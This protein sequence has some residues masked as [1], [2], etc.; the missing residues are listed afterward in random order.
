MH[1]HKNLYTLVKSI[2]SSFTSK[3]KFTIKRLDLLNI[4]FPWGLKYQLE[5]FVSRYFLTVSFTQRH[6]TLNSCDLTFSKTFLKCSRFSTKFFSGAF[7]SGLLI[8][9][10]IRKSAFRNATRQSSVTLNS[11]NTFCWTSYV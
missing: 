10:N 7:G 5:V 11:T 4:S 8:V 3:L 2:L 6:C 9:I 1:K